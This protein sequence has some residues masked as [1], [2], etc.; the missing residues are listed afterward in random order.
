MT[1]D[2]IECRTPTPAKQ[3]ARSERWKVDAMRE[4]ILAVVP[5]DGTA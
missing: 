2:R 5:G 1:T 3:L 4:A